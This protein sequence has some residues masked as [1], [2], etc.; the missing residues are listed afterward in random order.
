MLGA[1]VAL[2][3]PLADANHLRPLS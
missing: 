3:D 1:T 2:M